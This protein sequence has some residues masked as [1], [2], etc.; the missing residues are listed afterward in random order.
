MGTRRAGVGSGVRLGEAERGERA[1]GDEV[2]QP[3]VALLVAAEG[4]DRVDA[5]ADCSGQR[6]PD[7]LVGAAELFD[8]EAE[9]GEVSRR[10]RRTARG[11]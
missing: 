10:R 2:G 7:G 4:E 5:E 8:G 3:T 1:S 9:G 11:R 6:D